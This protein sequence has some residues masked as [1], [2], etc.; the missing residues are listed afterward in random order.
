MATIPLLAQRELAVLAG[1]SRETTSR[2]MSKLR[3]KG[4][5]EV[6]DEGMRLLT[7]EPLEKRCLLRASSQPLVSCDEPFPDWVVA[8]FC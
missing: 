4:Q 7:T 8:G 5:L 1:L 6:A 3:Q 2:T